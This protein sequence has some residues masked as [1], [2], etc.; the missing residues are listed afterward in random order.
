MTM[1]LVE[2]PRSAPRG[3]HGA[4]HRTTAQ[5]VGVSADEL[6]ADGVDA[7][8][9]DALYQWYEQ[10]SIAVDVFGP[11]AF[12]AVAYARR[13]AGVDAGGGHVTA[14]EAYRRGL[15][16]E[17]A[18]VPYSPGMMR[19]EPCHRRFLNRRGER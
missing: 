13:V 16:V 7:A 4:T 1:T 2:R 11:F 19:C 5:P 14:D 18:E 12:E 3:R 10:R 17:C 8:L 6:F 9:R 15:C